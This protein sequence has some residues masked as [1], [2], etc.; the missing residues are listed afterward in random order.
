[1]NEELTYGTQ[2]G[3]VHAFS[4]TCFTSEVDLLKECDKCMLA[5]VN[6]INSC[7]GNTCEVKVEIALIISVKEACTTPFT[8]SITITGI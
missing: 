7:A 1:V 8:A 3:E 2:Q 5:T 6:V 4:T